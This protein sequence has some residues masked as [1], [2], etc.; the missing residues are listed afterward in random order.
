MEILPQ[1]AQNPF[2]KSSIKLLTFAV[3]A[4]DS[5]NE[6]HVFPVESRQ[7]MKLRT[8]L[9]FGGICAFGGGCNQ[10]DLAFRSSDAVPA[11]VSRR[12]DALDPRQADKL[13]TLAFEQVRSAE[14]RT[15]YTTDYGNGFRKGF[16]DYLRGTTNGE[17][18]TA[19]PEGYRKSEYETPQG[20][21]A[22]KDWFRGYHKGAL[23]AQASGLRPTNPE[24][25]STISAKSSET[26][27]STAN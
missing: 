14:L 5:R 17:P 10:L 11:E 9:V 2:P 25:A 7:A 13:A 4:S 8:A 12:P 6:A 21:L 18:P 3:H 1:A 15:A 23:E 19:P 16:A 22:V 24:S 26:S 20:R 27:P